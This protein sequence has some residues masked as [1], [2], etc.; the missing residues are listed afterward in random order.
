MLRLRFFGS[1]DVSCGEKPIRFPTKKSALLLAYLVT[2][3]DRAHPRE[4]L[5]GL[6][7]GDAPQASAHSSLRYALTILRK[8]LPV[9]QASL[10][11]LLAT[12]G[13]VRFNEHAPFELDTLRLESALAKAQRE[14]SLNDASVHEL[15]AAVALYRGPFLEGFFEEWVLQEQMHWQDRFLEGVLFLI[16]FYESRGEHARTIELCRQAIRFCPLHEPL[17]QALMGAYALQGN[18][19]AALSQYEALVEKL[20]QEMRLD[21]LPETQLLYEQIA[22]HRLAPARPIRRFPP[23]DLLKDQA[24]FIGREDLTEQLLK[25]WKEIQQ[26]RRRALFL[27]GEPGIGKSRF[28]REVIH[29]LRAKGGMCLHTECLPTTPA[30]FEPIA[31]ALQEAFTDFRATLKTLPAYLQVEIQNLIPAWA[32][33]TRTTAASPPDQLQARRFQALTALIRQ[34]A[35]D[36]PLCLAL[37]DLHLA[38]ESTLQW[39]DYAFRRLKDI[40]L[41]FLGGYRDVLTEGHPLSSL[42]ANLG[43]QGLL[44]EW[45]IPPLSPDQSAE[46]LSQLFQRPLANRDPLNAALFHVSGG[47]PFYL[48]ALANGLNE[49]G[50]LEK[51][52]PEETGWTAHL[53]R[54]LPPTAQAALQERL[55]RVSARARRLLETGSILGHSWPFSLVAAVSGQ[56]RTALLEVVKE[57]LHARLFVEQGER[58]SFQHDLIREY[59]YQL[60]PHAQRQYLHERAALALERQREIQEVPAAALAWHFERASR[61]EKAIHYGLLAAGQAVQHNALHEAL[62][63]LKQVETQLGRYQGTASIPLHPYVRQLHTQRAAIYDAL[64]DR[65]KQL[66]AIHALEKAAETTR[67]LETRLQAHL[68]RAHWARVSGRFHEAIYAPISTIPKC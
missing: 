29:R 35:Q 2:F 31:Q 27:K 65:D 18:R 59:V 46:L 61:S 40:P 20:H 47:N 45:E 30:P 15:E 17:Y 48:C 58:Y 49:S 63:H 24:S 56:R 41:L 7:W 32:P 11:Y 57:L 14:N 34:S 10:P 62:G 43:A 67:G 52:G 8:A 37:D 26:G 55:R 66:G 53:V 68:H 1:L 21:P 22:S 3:R 12:G 38:D 44:E 4:T 36:Q 42:R 16:Q 25:R 64:G 5:A 6:F 39:I 33:S 9:P 28:L 23:V 60:L 54:Y 13:T 19:S 51:S 50:L